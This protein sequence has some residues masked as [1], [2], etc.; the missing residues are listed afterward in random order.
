MKLLLLMRAVMKLR[1]FIWSSCIAFFTLSPQVQAQADSYPNRPVRLIVPFAAGGSMD[2]SGR[3]LASRLSKYWSQPVVVENRGG[4]GGLIGVQELLKASPDGYTLLLAASSL[5]LLPS[6][7]KD[8]RF[9][10]ETSLAPIATFST[11]GYAM[12]VNEAL[13]IDSVKDFI[14][15]ANKNPGSVNFASPGTGSSNHLVGELFK[16]KAGLDMVHVPYKGDGPATTAMMAGEVQM[17]FSPLLNALPASRSGKVKILAV[18]SPERMQGEE[19]SE[20]PTVDESGL[21]GFNAVWFQGL[22]TLAGTPLA[23]LDKLYADTT[24]VLDDPVVQRELLARG[25][26]PGTDGPGQFAETFSREIKLWSEVA[27]AAG[28]EPQ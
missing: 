12:L 24:K 23:V 2:F 15:Y 20:F 21:P 25:A 8:L 26:V 13:Q 1:T 11:G 17:S 18:T 22:F 7:R 14:N 28:I 6:T 9:D 27:E 19:V 4:A 10:I 5:A 16:R 3:L